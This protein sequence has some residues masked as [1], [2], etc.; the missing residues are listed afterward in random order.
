MTL[1][2]MNSV[3]H[4]PPRCEPSNRDLRPRS[5]GALR[6]RISANV[7]MPNSAIIAMKSCRNP[8]TAQW[9]TTG[10]AKL[11]VTPSGRVPPCSSA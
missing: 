3:I 2:I 10:M 5:L 6:S 4:A 7:R 8:S 1:K 9:P 11:S